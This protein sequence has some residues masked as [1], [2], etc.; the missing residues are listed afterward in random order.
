MARGKVFQVDRLKFML[1]YYQLKV[2]PFLSFNCRNIKVDWSLKRLR[3]VPKRDHAVTLISRMLNQESTDR[4]R[5][6]LPSFEP[7]F[8]T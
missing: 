3:S 2:F 7:S 8:K 4:N 1:Q 5:S 6:W